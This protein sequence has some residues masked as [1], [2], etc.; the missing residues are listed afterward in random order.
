MFEPN[1]AV[2]VQ[3]DGKRQP[4]RF[5]GLGPMADECSVLIEGKRHIVKLAAVEKVPEKK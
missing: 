1:E 2:K 5:E 4:G 3:L